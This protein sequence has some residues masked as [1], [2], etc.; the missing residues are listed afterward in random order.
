[1]NL[2]VYDIAV[3]ASRGALVTLQGLLHRAESFC[4]AEGSEPGTLIEARL[5]PDMAP[6]SQQVVIVTDLARRGVTRLAGH[7][8]ESVDG[9]MDSF[10]AMRNRIEHA[11]SVVDAVSPAAFA[12]V[13]EQTIRF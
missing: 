5:A 3:P 11:R 9:P 8:P 13:A 1:M 4:E 10:E 7:T 6:L 12:E 2:T